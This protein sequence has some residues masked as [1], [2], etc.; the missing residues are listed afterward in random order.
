MTRAGQWLT[1]SAKRGNWKVDFLSQA[2]LPD[3]RRLI[4]VNSNRLLGE[5]SRSVNNIDRLVAAD[6][7]AGVGTERAIAPR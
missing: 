1:V 4:P 5:Y 6:D 7:L 3:T 2:V